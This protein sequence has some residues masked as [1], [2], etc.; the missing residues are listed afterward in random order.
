MLG[1][2]LGEEP[3]NFLELWNS[4]SSGPGWLRQP[5]VALQAL[6]DRKSVV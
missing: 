2:E 4:V 6:A 1:L 5:V 3:R